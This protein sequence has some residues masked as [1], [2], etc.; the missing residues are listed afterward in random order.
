M[1]D[2]H[3]V[4][5]SML[6]V[7][8]DKD[9]EAFA[10]QLRYLRGGGAVEM[11]QAMEG[12]PAGMSPFGAAILFYLLPGLQRGGIVISPRDRADATR[13]DMSCLM[14]LGQFLSSRVED[15]DMP[16]WL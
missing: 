15:D 3:G 13:E 5:E 4:E 10:P 6:A 9:F 2:H 16:P 7:A 8:R 12:S 11:L 1:N 14:S